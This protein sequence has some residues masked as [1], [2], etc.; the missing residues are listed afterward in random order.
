MGFIERNG[1]EWKESE[2]ECICNGK[3]W[4]IV[5]FR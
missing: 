4:K 2:M 3:E 5:T 1:K